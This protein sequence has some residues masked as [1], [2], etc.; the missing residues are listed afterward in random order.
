MADQL[1]GQQ[2]WEVPGVWLTTRVTSVS[3][4]PGRRGHLETAKCREPSTEH[5]RPSCILRLR[6]DHTANQVTGSPR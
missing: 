5:A 6:A 3:T 2:A 4:W 1:L